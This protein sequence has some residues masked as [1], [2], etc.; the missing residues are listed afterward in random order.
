[1]ECLGTVEWGKSMQHTLI[2]GF[3]LPTPQK[4]TAIAPTCS[5]AVAGCALTEIFSKLGRFREDRR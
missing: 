5:Q 3:L 2:L 1:M 4:E